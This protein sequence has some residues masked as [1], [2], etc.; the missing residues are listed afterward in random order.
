MNQLTKR[1]RRT[2]EEIQ[3][4]LDNYQKS[5]QSQ[6]QFAAQAG[7]CLAT[8]QIWLR[9]VRKAGA[10]RGQPMARPRLLEVQLPYGSQF[11][12]RQRS[13]CIELPQGAILRVE[14][15]FDLQEVGQLL[16]LLAGV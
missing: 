1:R 15:G 4:L 12:R 6:R 7:V 3:Q 8:L 2:P 14:S 5:G 11:Q 13:Y 16:A 9:R 10:V